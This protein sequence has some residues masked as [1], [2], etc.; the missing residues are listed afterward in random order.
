MFAFIV[1]VPCFFLGVTDS[2]SSNDLIDIPTAEITEYH[3]MDVNFRLYTGGGIV[4]RLSFGVFN[5]LNVGG[6]MDVDKLIGS[7]PP[8]VRP[9]V[10]Y[11]KFRFYDG[12]D[13]LP[14]LALG[15]DGQGYDYNHASGT[16]I[17]RE[18]GIYLV[19]T[20]ET[21]LPNLE[22]TMG[23]NLNFTRTT[24]RDEAHLYGF[25]GV[26]YSITDQGKKVLSII[27]EYNNLS[28]NTDDTILNAGLRFH[29]AFDLDIDFSFSDI[30]SPRKTDPE[31]LI[32]INYRT[33]F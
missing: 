4:S 26:D 33:K 10:F 28:R 32:R 27:G 20:L 18:K 24:T 17:H 14:A 31:R 23:A 13:R 6:S 2:H 3:T 22:L 11:F 12:S 8:E 19:A 30:M 7:V 5:Q 25:A 29:P 16:Y 15:Y 1:F 21:L 9:P